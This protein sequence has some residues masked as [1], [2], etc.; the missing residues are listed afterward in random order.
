MKMEFENR[1]AAEEYFERQVDGCYNSDN[2]FVVEIQE[3]KSYAE[4]CVT[5]P[6]KEEF[7]YVYYINEEGKKVY[8][9][10]KGLTNDYR[11]A[12]KFTK[13][14]GNDKA[15]NATENGKQHWKTEAAV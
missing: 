13:K 1:T 2:L 9:A 11:A 6:E 12:K 7:V 14:A 4:Q 15:K 5:E 3:S 8:I 10:K